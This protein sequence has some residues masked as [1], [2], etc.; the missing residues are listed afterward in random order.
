MQKENALTTWNIRPIL[1]ELW[2]G[3][4]LTEKKRKKKK[5]NKEEIGHSNCIQGQSSALLKKRWDKWF[6][7][8]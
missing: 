4:E 1:K 5:E 7:A 6:P 2:I 3:K 8:L